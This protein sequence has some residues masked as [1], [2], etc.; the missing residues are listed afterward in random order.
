MDPHPVGEK[1]REKP[2]H[3]GDGVCAGTT[4]HQLLCRGEV[5]LG[6][7]EERYFPRGTVP[8]HTPTGK[9]HTLRGRSVG[10][11]YLRAGYNPSLEEGETQAQ[12]P[13]WW[14]TEKKQWGGGSKPQGVNPEPKQKE[15][16]EDGV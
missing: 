4:L 11:A 6:E 1:R 5:V 7:R 15:N 10:H 2:E 13:W 3:T 9:A 16:M 14:T 8:A 12:G